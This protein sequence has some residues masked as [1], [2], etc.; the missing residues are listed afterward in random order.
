MLPKVSRIII[1]YVMLI[2]SSKWRDNTH[3]NDSFC[4]SSSSIFFFISFSL[5]SMSLSSS[6]LLFQAKVVDFS[7]SLSCCSYGFMESIWKNRIA[8][9]FDQFLMSNSIKTTLADGVSRSN[10]FSSF[11]RS[12]ALAPLCAQRVNARYESLLLAL[13]RLCI[14]LPVCWNVFRLL[15][16]D[17]KRCSQHNDDDNDCG[18][19]DM[20]DKWR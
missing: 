3:H 6:P 11:Q 5:Q 9:T 20:F 2:N 18:L 14:S 17:V 13:E 1:K 19:H 16:N 4:S 12:C 7:V 8:H 10:S 15:S